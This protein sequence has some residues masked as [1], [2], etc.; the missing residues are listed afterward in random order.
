MK[1]EIMGKGCAKCKRVERNVREAVKELGL[2]IEIVKVD[3]FEE[4]LR[5]G[6]MMT[7]GLSIDGEVVMY[8][9]VPSVQEVKELLTERT[10]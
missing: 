5:R 9:R 2:D 7:P 1:V 3:D 8:G 6:I 10:T 4:I